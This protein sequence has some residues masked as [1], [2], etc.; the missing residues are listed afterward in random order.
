MGRSAKKSKIAQEETKKV[1]DAQ[2]ET[3]DEVKQ[4]TPEEVNQE[5]T[6]EVNTG[7]GEATEGTTQVE[8]KSTKAADGDEDTAPKKQKHSKKSTENKKPRSMNAFLIFSNA[9]R[10]EIKDTFELVSAVEIAKKLGELW[11][12]ADA[13]TKAK[14]ETIAKEEKEKASVVEGI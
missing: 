5:T 4:Q 1:D 12:N 2:V 10:Q 11:R 7:A 8:K 14:Y 13:E 9:K 6:Q 3:V